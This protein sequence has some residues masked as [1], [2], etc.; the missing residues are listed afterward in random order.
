MS[1]FTA[2]FRTPWG[3][4]WRRFGRPFSVVQTSEPGE[5]RRCLEQVEREV[6]LR[7]CHAA[8]FVTYDAA[9]AF[10]LPVRR[11]DTLPL[12][13]FGLFHA[14]EVAS[15]AALPSAAAHHVG[16]WRAGITREAYSAAIAAIKRRIEAGDTYQINFT[17]PL[18][19][20]FEG[21]ALGLFTELAA[22]QAGRW[23]AYLDVGSHAICSASPEL[24]FS[25]EDGRIE[26]RPMKGTAKRGLDAATDRRQAERLQQSQKDRAE[27]VM[28]V[29][30]VRNDLGRIATIGSVRVESLFS[31]ERFP[32]QWQMTSTVTASLRHGRDDVLASIF[33]ALFP[34]ASIT[35]APKHSAMGIIRELEPEA[36]GLYTGAIGYLAPDMRAQFNVAIRTVTVDR[37]RSLARFGAGSGIVWDSQEEAEYDECL[38]KASILTMHRSADR[39]AFHLLETMRWTPEHGIYLL[40]R[41]LARLQGSAEYFDFPLDATFVRS[42]LST[43]VAGRTAPAKIRLLLSSDGGVECQVSDLA[44]VHAAPMTAAFAAAP[45][46]TAD[47]FLYHKTTER[48]VYEAAQASR[49]DAEA[50]LLWNAA[51]DVTEATIFNVVAEIGGRKVTP[52]VESGLLAGTLR[53]E[54]LERGEIV[55]ARITMAELRSASQVWGVNSVMGW[56]R[57]RMLPDSPAD[58]AAT[59]S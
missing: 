45:V 35:G 19:A 53:A 43:A 18:S 46:D 25:L 59:A 17:F 58:P 5:V 1:P 39:T 50:V 2:L 54:L 23:A 4:P 55:E 9:G 31:V 7:G 51:G 10:Q 42:R 30:M 12:V 47:V 34:C 52:P 6:R 40:E 26:C 8:G 16:A 27:N 41:H 20:P 37:H 28:V 14:D 21:D 15:L 49:P 48:R 44:P 33:E 22:A 57:F 3:G 24:F 13:W 29:D 32:A 36:R 56:R 38:L 11:G